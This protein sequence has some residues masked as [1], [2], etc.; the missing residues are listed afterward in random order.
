VLVLLVAFK[1]LRCRGLRLCGSRLGSV[2]GVMCVGYSWLV[3]LFLVVAVCS[4]VCLTCVVFLSSL[5]FFVIC[6]CWCF[7]V[8]LFNI[9]CVFVIGVSHRFYVCVGG[10][11]VWLLY[12]LVVLVFGCVIEFLGF[13]F[14]GGFAY[15]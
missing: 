4:A 12:L 14:V 15:S 5:P 2:S 3:Y 8:D 1:V 6:W 9:C 10:I 7:V 13:V 11:G